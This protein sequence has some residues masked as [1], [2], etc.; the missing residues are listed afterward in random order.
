MADIGGTHARFALARLQPDGP[1]ALSHVTTMATS[2]HASLEEAF[3]RFAASLDEP[4][5][6]KAAVAV[7]APLPRAADTPV[8]F[9]NNPWTIRV[10]ELPGQLG[11]AQVRLL[12]DF[13]SIAHAVAI[14][15]PH[16]F[17][18]ICGPRASLPTEGV[19]SVIGPGTGLG[20][21]MLVRTQGRQQI[22]PTEAGHIGFAP[23]DGLEDTLLSAMRRGLAGRVSMERLISGPGLAPIHLAMGGA[24]ALDQKSLWAEVL[25]SDSS[26]AAATLERYLGLLG[27]FA[28]DVALA[29]GASAVVIAG[30]LG[31]RL[32]ERLNHPAFAARFVEKGRFSRHLAALPV[33][34]L[35]LTEPGLLGAA[36]SIA[37][38]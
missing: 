6:A 23:G 10:R 1:P 36:A 31:Q 37:A 8:T 17:A 9:T 18:P 38:D 33:S 32:G 25:A 16:D 5:P 4:L 2:A 27:S 11:I 28:G 20:V 21:A 12:N 30:G 24:P 14:A 26:E 22:I 3:I 35:L 29:Q 13:E 19:V 7:A 15:A 34:R